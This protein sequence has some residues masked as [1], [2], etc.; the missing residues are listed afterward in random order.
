MERRDVLLT[1]G[2]EQTL[3]PTVSN[4]VNFYRIDSELLMFTQ[5]FSQIPLK[6]DHCSLCLVCLETAP[7]SHENKLFFNYI[8]R[9]S[10]NLLTKN[11]FHLST[12]L[13]RRF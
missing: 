9:L 4:C 11:I 3:T 7:H 8:F 1:L 6:C 2:Q 13:V 5:M 12:D 10:F